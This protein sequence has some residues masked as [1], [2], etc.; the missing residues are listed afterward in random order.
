MGIMVNKD[1][2][3][4]DELTRRINADLKAK[5][6]AQSKDSGERKDPDLV[7]DSE[8][9]KDF[10][11]TGRYAWVWV[12]LGILVVAGLVIFSVANRQN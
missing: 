10:S 3:A 8:Y 12:A 7:E 1:F 11:K 9:A 4:K 2:E 5:M 6:E